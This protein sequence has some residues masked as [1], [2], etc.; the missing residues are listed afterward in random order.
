MGKKVGIMTFHRAYNYGAALQAYSLQTILRSMGHA[1][2]FVDFKKGTRYTGSNADGAKKTGLKGLR[3]FLKTGI[4][5]KTLDSYFKRRNKDFELFHNEYMAIADKQCIGRRDLAAC[6]EK[7]DAV[8]A[9]SDQVWNPL[10]NDGDFCYLLPD[11]NGFTRISYAA[12]LGRGS[13]DGFCCNEQVREALRRFDYISVREE[14]SKEKLEAFVELE[15]PIE[16]TVDPTLL[17]K[18]SDF[19]AVASKRQIRKPYIF[20]YTVR[21]LK[22]TING[23]DILSKRTKLPVYTLMPGS[24]KKSMLKMNK[25]TAPGDAGPLGFL[26]M[27][28]D[29]DYV[30]TDSFHGSVFSVLFNKKVFI[31][32]EKQPDGG[33]VIDQRLD[34][35]CDLFGIHDRVISADGLKTAALETEPDWV[36]IEKKRVQAAE[37]S[38]DFLRSALGDGKLS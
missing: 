26:A 30:V 24:F 7:Y 9:G 12:S 2:E 16:L 35:L 25:N 8:I 21:G 33:L 10:L 6:L 15:K 28:R 36:S 4:A 3:Y 31:V 32:A 22:Q 27:I 34:G 37:H 5:K 1:S 17:L 19:N 38:L 23:A 13:F 18:A 14:G 29:A 20:L 11:G